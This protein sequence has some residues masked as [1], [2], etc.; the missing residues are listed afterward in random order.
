MK[1]A[2][3]LQL[4]SLYEQ[5]LNR[6]LQKNIALLKSIQEERRLRQ[7][8]EMEEAKRLLQPSE[9]KNISYDPKRDGFVF[10]INEMQHAIDRHRRL[11]P[12]KFAAQAA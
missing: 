6:T 4:L 3:N 12:R 10:S 11:K 8:A 9:M 2:K 1:Q 5:R 7:A